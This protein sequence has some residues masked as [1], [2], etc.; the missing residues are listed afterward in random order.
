MNQSLREERSLRLQGVMTHDHS[1]VHEHAPDREDENTA[2]KGH[3]YTEPEFSMSRARSQRPK[4]G[5][6]GGG[7]PVE[8]M[9]RHCAVRTTAGR[10]SNLLAG[11]TF[12]IVGSAS[13]DEPET[14]WSSNI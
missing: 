1:S 5:D 9:P 2:A 13:G 4:G 14:R 12:A 3:R 10:P 7:E 11:L 8:L 6:R